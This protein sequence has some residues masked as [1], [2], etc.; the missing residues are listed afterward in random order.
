[1]FG[2]RIIRA[3][4]YISRIVD[5][6]PKPLYDTGCTYCGTPEFPK[7]KGIDFEKNLNQTASQ[8]W[9]HV[10]VTLHG[11]GDFAEMPSKINLVPG[12]LANEFESSKKS[13]LSPTHPVLLSNII[14]NDLRTS[15]VD[16]SLHEVIV[17]P[18]GKLVR[19]KKE[20]LLQFIEHYLLP[21]EKSSVVTYN[22][23]TSDDKEE[24]VSVKRPDLFEEQD[25]GKDLV[26]VC[27][28]TQRDIRC[29]AL[30]PIIENEFTEVLEREGL[31]PSVD[32]GLISHIGGH[33][34]AGNVIY[35]PADTTLCPVVWYGRVFPEKVQGIV[36]ETVIGKKIIKELYRGDLRQIE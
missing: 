14:T 30:G 16:A 36:R 13:K 20:H 7:D 18:E 27:G 11:F 33:A 17:Y 31:A 21:D 15:F 2:V 25:F 1:M 12:S 24:H 29:G 9:K 8:P 6:C 35:F 5:N 28:H 22:P 19:F 10:L 32:V 34:Y 3:A 23:F 26:L 4:R